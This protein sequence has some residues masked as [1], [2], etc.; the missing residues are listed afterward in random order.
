[1][2][3]AAALGFLILIVWIALGLIYEALRSPEVEG[4]HHLV[5]ASPEE[6]EGKLPA[7][8]DGKLCVVL[9]TEP[10]GDQVAVLIRCREVER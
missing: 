10:V 3:N 7:F 2:R 6:L 1:V 5:V 9:Q 4:T 8:I